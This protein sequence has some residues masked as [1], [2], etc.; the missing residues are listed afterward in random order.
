M[1]DTPWYMRS[2]D[3]A[4]MRVGNAEANRLRLKRI[5]E[6][7]STEAD[8]YA[9]HLRNL[10]AKGIDIPAGERMAMG[11]ATNSRK[12]AALVDSV[13]TQ[14]VQTADN[15]HLT[16]DQRIARGYNSYK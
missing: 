4:N 8:T 3:S 6:T 7:A 16:P 10:E 13:P 15:D 11:Y 2:T 14:S 9:A 5:A 12:A 1:T